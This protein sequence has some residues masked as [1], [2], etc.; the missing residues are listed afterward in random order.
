[1]S[2]L[3]RQERASS[4][5]D[6]SDITRLGKLA[7]SDERYDIFDYVVNGVTYS[8]T[9]LKPFQRTGGHSHED[10]E[11]RYFFKRGK[12]EFTIGTT[13]HQIDCEAIR[14]SGLA[15]RVPKGA[16]HRVLNTGERTLTFVTIFPGSRHSVHSVYRSQTPNELSEELR[17]KP[18]FGGAKGN[19]VLSRLD[20][21][22]RNTQVL[23]FAGGLGKRMSSPL[24]KAMLEV[25]GEPL[26][27]RCVE[28]FA[29][30][31]FD[32]FVFLLGQGHEDIQDRIGD[33]SEFQ[34]KPTFSVDQKLG[35]G[36]AASMLQ[37]LRN[38]K[39]DTK[40]RSLVVFPDDIF[41]DESLPVRLILEHLYGVRTQETC[42]SLV[43][44]KG[45]RWPYGVGRVDES[46]LIRKFEEKPF[47]HEPTSVGLYLFEPS[48]YG[49]MEKIS[50]THN[51]WEIEDT[52]IP[53][54]AEAGKLYS[55]FVPPESWLPVNTQKDMEEAEQA[56]LRLRRLLKA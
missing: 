10:V 47:I 43:L 4:I 26:L 36:R 8:V 37:A 15:F 41:T 54:L 19:S 29:A 40:M 28:F 22:T 35:Q 13:T 39:I 50:R 52:L 20:E 6:V 27:D 21:E 24:P 31:G 46:G 1:M 14:A 32:E 56:L 48:V 9:E 38:G 45:R 12:G 18:Q 7:R 49:M 25:G 55:I 53:R 2:R 30:C 16:F 51:K 3:E 23:V 34:I 5:P 42:A 17:S 33:G 11:E 44:T